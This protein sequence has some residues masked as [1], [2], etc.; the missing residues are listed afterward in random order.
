MNI[1]DQTI[2]IAH[3]ADE[4]QQSVS[5]SG[6][7]AETTNAIGATTALV[8]STVEC[9]VVAGASPVATVA[10]GTPVPA[11]TVLRIYGLDPAT[12]KI[13]AITS[14]ATGTLYIRPN[15]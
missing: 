8:Y 6:T 9:F 2:R 1:S 4:G 15:A 10:A 3:S 12:D 14:S 13:S 7:H 11:T 5:V